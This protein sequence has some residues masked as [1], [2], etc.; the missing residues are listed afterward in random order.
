MLAW[1]EAWVLYFGSHKECSRETNDESL[2]TVS[3]KGRVPSNSREVSVDENGDSK[4][5]HV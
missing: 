4:V 3:E 5:E 1:L 2:V